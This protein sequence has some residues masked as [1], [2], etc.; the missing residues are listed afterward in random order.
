MLEPEV[1]VQM[2][3]E[4]LLDAEEAR[5][6]TVVLARAFGG[7][8]RSPAGSGDSCEVALLLV[9]FEHHRSASLDPVK[10]ADWLDEREHDDAGRDTD[11]GDDAE[12]LLQRHRLVEAGQP[13]ANVVADRRLRGT[14]RPS[15]GR[16]CAPARAWSWR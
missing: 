3:G 13:P 10:P 11:H 9:F 2:T 5:C 16:R 7:Q 8:F 1:V 6:C 14:T 4:V 12:E 15:S